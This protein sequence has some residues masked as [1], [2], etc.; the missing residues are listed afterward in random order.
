[1]T[2]FRLLDAL[3][4]NLQRDKGA[5]TIKDQ[6][7]P[8]TEGVIDLF[9][10]NKTTKEQVQKHVGLVWDD[11]DFGSHTPQYFAKVPKALTDTDELDILRNNTK[12]KHVMMCAKLLN[13]LR[14]KFQIDIQGSQLKS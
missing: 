2:V 9:K 1:M 5:S 4:I 12:L 11:S 7:I 3:K 10:S 14:S 8:N 13:S 6:R